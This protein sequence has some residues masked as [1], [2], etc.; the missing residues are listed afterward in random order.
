MKKPLYIIKVGGK[1]LDNQGALHGLLET[2]VA[3]GKDFVLVHGGGSHANRMAEKLGVP[4]NM[5]EGRRITD[6]ATLDIA[7]MCYAGLLNK[8][9]VASLQAIGKNCL[10]MSGADANSV[11]AGLRTNGSQDYGLVGDPLPE[12]VNSSFLESMI[13]QGIA[14]V[15]CALTH[16]EKGQML[17]TNADTMAQTLAIALSGHYAVELIYLFE[18]PGVLKEVNDPNS[19]IKRLTCADI[20]RLQAEKIILDGM[21]PKLQNASKAIHSGVKRVIIGTSSRLREILAG[22]EEVAT[23]VYP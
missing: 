7:L 16:D 9:L 6:S 19:M 10:G 23:Y 2:L 8:K 1:L 13:E 21:I 12:R 17:N 20:P 11:P 22:D 14:P 5:I 15:F 4:Q 18:K 3:F